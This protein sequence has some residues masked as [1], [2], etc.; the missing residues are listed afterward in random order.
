MQ[1]PLV[2]NES[3]EKKKIE[4]NEKTYS[5][6][7]NIDANGWL[8]TRKEK[9]KYI[10]TS[11]ESVKVGTR[12][13]CSHHSSDF[14]MLLGCQ[15]EK[16]M[17]IIMAS[18]PA[19]SPDAWVLVISTIVLP[20]NNIATTTL[21]EFPGLERIQCISVPNVVQVACLAA[22][23]SK[24]WCNVRQDYASSEWDSGSKWF[25]HGQSVKLLA[26]LLAQF[27]N[28]EKSLQPPWDQTIP[29]WEAQVQDGKTEQGWTRHTYKRH[30]ERRAVGWH[31]QICSNLTSMGMRFGTKKQEFLGGSRLKRGYLESWP[32]S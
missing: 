21:H 2:D 10:K 29:T 25:K 4:Q 6:T 31:L 28:L 18:G 20:L 26:S 22:R 17:G 8:D 15:A 3:S 11:G 1:S 9:Y 23:V 13:G 30:G 19:F 24:W 7:T 5:K 27:S 16:S 12:N 32:P 14:P